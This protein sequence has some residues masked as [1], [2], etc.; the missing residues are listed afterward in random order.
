MPPEWIDR[1]SHRVEEYRLPQGE[2][3]RQAL[4]TQ[5]GEDGQAV[6]QWL[7]EPTTLPDL[8]A[9]PVIQILRHVWEHQ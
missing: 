9:L 4:A 5:I 8:G 6:L 2:T 1:Y 7:E 3:A